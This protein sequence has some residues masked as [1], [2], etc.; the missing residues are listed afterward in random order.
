MPSGT[1][2]RNN[3]SEQLAFGRL[4]PRSGGNFSPVVRQ[5]GVAAQ[6]VRELLDYIECPASNCSAAVSF[7][8]TR[9]SDDPGCPFLRVS[10]TL[11]PNQSLKITVL[12]Y[13]LRRTAYSLSS[14]FRWT[15]SKELQFLTIEIAIS[16]HD[17]CI[18]VFLRA[19]EQSNN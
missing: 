8:E 15:L 13:S 11:L 4:S 16:R 1:R 9:P 14:T 19:R 2:A 10:W 7:G 5:R 3:G 6:V 17:A 12:D 18:I